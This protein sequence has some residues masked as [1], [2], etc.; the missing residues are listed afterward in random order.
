MG[1]AA[2]ITQCISMEA[3]THKLRCAA[4]VKRFS[5]FYQRVSTSIKLEPISD[6]YKLIRMNSFLLF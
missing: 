2:L 5:C 1:W 4:S 6:Q 3:F